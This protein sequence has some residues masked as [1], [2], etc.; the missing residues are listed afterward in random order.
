M[1][2]FFCCMHSRPNDYTTVDLYNRT[3]L[4]YSEDH[5]YYCTLCNGLKIPISDQQRTSYT[6][7][8]QCCCVS[9]SHSINVI[10]AILLRRAIPQYYTIVGTLA[11]CCITCHST[12]VLALHAILVYR[13]SLSMWRLEPTTQD[14]M[15]TDIRDGL[16]R[17][18]LYYSSAT[19]VEVEG[20]QEGRYRPRAKIMSYDEVGRLFADADH[21]DPRAPSK[22]VRNMQKG[23]GEGT[24]TNPLIGRAH[25]RYLER[26]SKG[27]EQTDKC[28]ILRVIR[29]SEASV[30]CNRYY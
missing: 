18:R 21:G 2:R 17:G 1:W 29:L 27:D 26:H 12:R 22:S 5:I 7:S 9:M 3:F 16:D 8:C 6:F 30:R 4:S 15:A 24:H 13:G 28:T 11:H 25:C 19:R 10:Y 23:A 14:K 20:H